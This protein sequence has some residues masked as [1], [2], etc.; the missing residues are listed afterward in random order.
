MMRTRVLAV[1]A[2]TLVIAVGL[3]SR[4]ADSKHGPQPKSDAKSPPAAAQP[5]KPAE[6]VAKPT[7]SPAKPSESKAK[8]AAAKSVEKKSRTVVRFTLK[9][10]YAE[11]PSQPGLFGDMQPSLGKMIQRMDEAA[12]DKTV[13]AVW[14]RIEDLEIGR[15]KIE[16]LRGAVG[17]LRKAGKPVYAELTTAETGPY[18]LAVACDEVFM[19]SSGMLLL[20]GVRAEVTFYKGLLDK[21][22]VEFDALQMGKYKGAVEPLT[23]K[24]MSGPL[25]ESLESLVDD[26]YEQAVAEIAK[27]RH[28]KD[29]QVKTLID[30]GMFTASMAQKAGL[31]DQVLYA[32]QFEDSLRKKLGGPV[33][34][35]TTYRKKQIDTDFSG[36]GGL[37]KLMELFSGG[38][39][40]EKT[41]AKQ[42][43]AVVY[44]VGPIVEGKGAG[45]MFGE[46]SLG[47]TTMIEAL[48]KAIDDPKVVA[49]VLRIDSPGGSAT[50]SDLIW[51]Q[52]MR[53]GKPLVASMG[54]VAG[55][56]GYYIA[57]GARKIFAEPDTITGSIGVIGGKMVTRGLFDKLG[58][59]TEIISRGK[60]SGSLSSSQPFSPDERKAWIDLLTETYNQF[61]SKAAQGRKMDRNRLAELAQGRVYSGRTAKRL[62]LIDELGTLQDA[63]AEAKKAAGLKPDADVDLLILPRP[64]TIFEQLFGDSAA[65]GELESVLPEAMTA[66]RLTRIW[67]QLFTEPVLMWMPYGIRLR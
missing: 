63:I 10:D 52:T 26:V 41:G 49:I 65:A 29:Y 47:S 35:V 53:T 32:D 8:K 44:A 39:A 4:A 46:T 19:P 1:V 5:A 37:M 31:I 3:T 45:D 30:Q 28:M 27:D 33:E 60:N 11:G 24:T 9:G 12:T 58:L 38:K 23:R 2:W 36:I 48:Q 16:E 20:P 13:A 7:D 40:S 22:G 55:S 21:L 64:K 50:A 42:R 17:R 61:V 18:L 59:N 15:G 66:L 6:N 56:G 43:I 51:R 67:R 14:L 25:R 34:V 54:D 57:M 62:G